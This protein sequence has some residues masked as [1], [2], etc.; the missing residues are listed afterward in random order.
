MDILWSDRKKIVI[1]QNRWVSHFVKLLS[2]KEIFY[3]DNYKEKYYD[4]V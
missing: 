1:S 2:E 3:N 4:K